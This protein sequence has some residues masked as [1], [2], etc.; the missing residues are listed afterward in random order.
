M[1][2][3]FDGNRSPHWSRP[4][5][6]HTQARTNKHALNDV[7]VGV[8]DYIFN[9]DLQKERE[10]L[11][12]NDGY[13]RHRQ[14]VR[15]C[16]AHICML[17]WQCCILW[18]NF[19]IHF[20]GCILLLCA[21]HLPSHNACWYGGVY[22]GNNTY[23]HTRALDRRQADGWEQLSGCPLSEVPCA[24]ER[25]PFTLALWVRLGGPWAWPIH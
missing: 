7:Y 22:W 5:H 18:L 16:E 15:V 19:V 24:P 20:L 3:S 8:R 17:T 12:G 23:T 21:N 4:K 10:A 11:R 25:R 2:I 9:S 1:Y 6:T 13:A 14:C